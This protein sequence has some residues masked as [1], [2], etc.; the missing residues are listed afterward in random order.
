MKPIDLTFPKF[1]YISLWFYYDL[2][3]TTAFTL[4][5]HIYISLW[6]YYDILLPD[7]SQI[8][9]NHLHF[10]LI[11]LWLGEIIEVLLADFK[12][13]FHSDSIMTK[14]IRRSASTFLNLHF[15]LILL[16]P[17]RCVPWPLAS[18]IYISLWFYYDSSLWNCWLCLHS[19][20]ISVVLQV[21]P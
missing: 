7:F 8:L 5:R 2:F 16:W 6:F 13:T 3:I 4:D 14:Q 20:C 12:F 21:K 19:T 9:Q 18:G 11:L 15:T 17:D 1:I 10:T